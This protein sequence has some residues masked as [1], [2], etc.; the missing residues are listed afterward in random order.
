MLQARWHN[1]QNMGSLT[2]LSWYG[3]IDQQVIDQDRILV[4]FSFQWRGRVHINTEVIF[5]QFS[6]DYTNQFQLIKHIFVGLNFSLNLA[7]LPK[8]YAYGTS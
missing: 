3:K 1:L 2:L 6:I 8:P 5:F 7:L 4:Q